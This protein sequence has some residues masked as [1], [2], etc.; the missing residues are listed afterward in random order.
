MQ[1]DVALCVLPQAIEEEVL[2]HLNA[3]MWHSSVAFGW[4]RGDVLCVDNT[5]VRSLPNFRRSYAEE[6][7]DNLARALGS[8][9]A[10]WK[11]TRCVLQAMH[12]RTSFSGPRKIVV[13]FSSV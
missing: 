1:C 11:L 4:S 8:L 6:A 7:H 3:C 13:G 12:A 10:T 2:E 5:T 9:H